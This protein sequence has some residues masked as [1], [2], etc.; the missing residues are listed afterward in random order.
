MMNLVKIFEKHLLKFKFL[1]TTVS[2]IS[3]SLAMNVEEM[4]LAFKGFLRALM[5]TRT[6]YFSRQFIYT[7]IVS[8]VTI[9]VS[10]TYGASRGN[11]VDIDVANQTLTEV[12]TMAGEATWVS[13]FINNVS[14]TLLTFLP[15]LG[16]VLM[17]YVQYNTGWYLGALAKAYDMDYIVATSLILTSVVGLLEYSAY[18]IALG[19]SMFLV[20]SAAQKG[21]KERLM[22]HSWKSIIIVVSLLFIGGVVE[23]FLLGRL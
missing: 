2:I 12:A 23:A 1:V 13:I 15:I 5:Q 17:I 8:A 4:G 7:L 18:I 11:Q 21:L 19:E 3:L 6:P 22:Y 14:I 16:L 10:L 20:Y 9:F